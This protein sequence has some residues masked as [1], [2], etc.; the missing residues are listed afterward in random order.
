MNEK[1]ALLKLDQ[2]YAQVGA[3]RL[4]VKGIDVCATYRKIKPSLP[5]VMFLAGMIP[6][7]GKKIVAVMEVVIQAA[8]AG[9]G[10]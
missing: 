2:A 8:D 7:I 1:T 6:G 10:A 5:Y 4:G 3:K 9:C